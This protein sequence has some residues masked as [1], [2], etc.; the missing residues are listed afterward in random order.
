LRP[1]IRRIV[2]LLF[3]FLP[4]LFFPAEIQVRV[5][6][7]RA[8]HTTIAFLKNGQAESV[9]LNGIDCLEK[10]QDFGAQA[11]QLTRPGCWGRCSNESGS[12][13]ATISFT[14][15]HYIVILFI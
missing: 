12:M 5:P 8:G 11:E 6:N 14:C 3:L 15:F 4:Q 10:G 9:R 13:P 1:V 7:V 2:L